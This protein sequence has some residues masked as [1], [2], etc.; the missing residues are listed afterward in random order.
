MVRELGKMEGL[1]EAVR[2]VDRGVEVV[3]GGSGPR[4]ETA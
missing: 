2:A 1:L 3:G 4:V